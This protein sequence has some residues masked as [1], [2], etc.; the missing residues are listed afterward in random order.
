[1]GLKKVAVHNGPFHP[2]DVFSFAILKLIYPNLEVVR[3]RDVG[4]LEKVDARIDVG[5]K[6]SHEERNYDHHQNGGAGKRENGIPYASIGLIW[7]HYG[8]ELAGSKDVWEY[9][10]KR[11]I[12]YID[13][14]DNGV[15]VYSV[16]EFEPY[17]IDNI[18]EGLNPNWPNLSLGI[19]DKKF[20]EAVEIVIKIMKGEIER[21]K[22]IFDAEKLLAKK[23][24]E[25]KGKDYIILE[26]YMPYKEYLIKNSKLK[27]VVMYDGVEKHWV[28]R[29]LGVN[30][31]SFECRAYFPEGWAGLSDEK[32]EKESGIK[33]A[34]FCHNKRFIFIAKTKEGAV[35]AVEKALKGK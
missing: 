28:A 3:T 18:I 21:A 4:E 30:A 32:L 33:G 35:E 23:V 25:Q 12:Q 29:A 8:M 19:Y 22:G 10:D 27:F 15:S 6:Y 14:D 16:K 24:K 11:I 2:D 1:M 34:V 20:L 17:K 13:A 26:S 5:R 7:K 9:I 31:D